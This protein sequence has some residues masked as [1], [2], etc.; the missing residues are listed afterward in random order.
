MNTS[1]FGRAFIV[2]TV[3]I[4]K[5]IYVINVFEPP[6]DF[7]KNINKE[8]FPY[9]FTGTLRNVKR[10]TLAQAKNKGGINVQL[11]NTKL[12]ALRIQYISEIIKSKEK[13]PL[14]HYFIGIRLFRYTKLNHNMPHFFGTHNQP[15]Y[16]SC[17]KII[18]LYPELIGKNTK[19][20]YVAITQKLEPPLNERIKAAYKC[21]IVDCT[22][23]FK[24][25]HN[26]FSTITEKEITYRLLFNMTP[27][28]PTLKRCPFCKLRVLNEEHLFAL[29]T[30]LKPLKVS[31][32]ATTNKLLG[33]KT[34]SLY[35]MIMLNLIPDTNTAIRNLLLHILGAYRHHI[36][37]SFTKIINHKIDL[38]VPIMLNIWE[39]KEIGIIRS[40]TQ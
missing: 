19:S 40:H 24:N 37:T 38:K 23:C 20:A 34:S 30:A 26:K 3:I 11:I 17:T 14:A 10:N 6:T 7:I 21:L 13:W 15:F 29:C 16:R 1:I 8:I 39:E 4:S 2:N 12:E 22:P 31:L 35:K 33:N 27:I 25:T 9:I 28:R 32:K 18:N 5:L 36:W